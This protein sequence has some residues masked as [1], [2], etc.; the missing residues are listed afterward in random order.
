[1][2][3]HRQMCDAKVGVFNTTTEGHN[4][5]SPAFKRSLPRGTR[6]NV[7]HCTPAPK[8]QKVPEGIEPSDLQM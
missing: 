1:M 7:L 5:F 6:E 4:W 8:K 2:L 3:K